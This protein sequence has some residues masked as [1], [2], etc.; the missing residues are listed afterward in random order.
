MPAPAA[1]FLQPNPLRP[2]VSHDAFA[3]QR[4]RVRRLADLGDENCL[5]TLAVLG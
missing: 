1:L 5:N 4:A 2:P 3:A